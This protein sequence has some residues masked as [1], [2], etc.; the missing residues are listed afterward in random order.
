M[1][2]FNRERIAGKTLEQLAGMR[3]AGLLVGQTLA[4]LAD[5]VRPGMTT[6]ELD[7]LA[8]THIRDHGGVPNFQ[9]VP[10]YRHTLCTSVNDEIVHG[11]PGDR[12]LQEGDL[13]SIDCGAQVGQW[14]GDAAFSCI[15]GGREAET[16]AVSLRT[17]DES[18]ASSRTMSATA[19]G[20][21][22]TWTR[23]CRTTASPA[24][25]RR[26]PRG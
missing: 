26:C 9:L 19:S 7:T 14:N 10:G 12:V 20:P 15:V 18:T 5:T 16:R 24:R 3:V 8:E 11:I 21:R 1:G 23:R 17:R 6:L 2:L 25:A 22:C 13:L 4:L